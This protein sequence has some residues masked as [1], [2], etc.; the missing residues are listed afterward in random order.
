MF[1]VNSFYHLFLL[2]IFFIY[3]VYCI[4]S[5]FQ[6]TFGYIYM[7][8]HIEVTKFTRPLFDTYRLWEGRDLYR[9]TPAETQ[10]LGFCGFVQRNAIFR[11]ERVGGG[12]ED[13]FYPA[14][15]RKGY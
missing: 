11:P 10:D 1:E 13:Q 15:P 4:N 5:D 14:S 2:F 9:A 8:L 3:T 12:G 7:I 6:Q